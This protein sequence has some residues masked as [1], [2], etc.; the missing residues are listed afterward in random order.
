MIFKTLS[1]SRVAFPVGKQ[2]MRVSIYTKVNIYFNQGVSAL[3]ASPIGLFYMPSSLV[4]FKM[5]ELQKLHQ[6][7]NSEWRNISSSEGH[8]SS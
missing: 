2:H 5:L 4:Q 8:I 6:Y 7:L 1:S 3:Q